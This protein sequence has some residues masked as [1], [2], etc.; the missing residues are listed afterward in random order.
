MK[1]SVPHVVAM[2]TLVLGLAVSL[3]LTGCTPS[4]T[5]ESTNEYIGDAAISTKVRAK[6]LADSDVKISDIKV[7]TYRGTVQLG[8]YVSSRQMAAKAEEDAKSISGVRDV[9]NNLVIRQ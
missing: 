6:I 1:T 3:P 9:K 5:S 2:A 7:T 4:A 8:G